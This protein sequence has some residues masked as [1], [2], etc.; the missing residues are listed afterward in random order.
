VTERIAEMYSAG[1][2]DESYRVDE[3]DSRVLCEGSEFIGPARPEAFDRAGQGFG[4]AG[5]YVWDT[6][7]PWERP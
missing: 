6:S 7:L 5:G 1:Q 3:D 2:F 4:I